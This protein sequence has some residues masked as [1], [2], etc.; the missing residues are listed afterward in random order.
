VRIFITYDRED[1]PTVTQ[2]GADLE[3]SEREVWIEQDLTGGQSWWEEILNH[4]R[5]CDLYIFAL[6]EFSLASRPCLRELEYA[7]A[8]G[9]PILPV[10]V[11]DVSIQQAPQVIVD[12]QVVNYIGRSA[13]GVLALRDALD[14]APPAPA[15]PDP[16]PSPPS[17]PISYFGTYREQ[18]DADSLCFADQQSLLAE[19]AGYIAND[20]DRDD[21]VD[22]LGALRGRPDVAY[23]VV[24]EIDAL[25]ES[26]PTPA[27]AT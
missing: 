15:L 12:S 1:A 13:D 14:A 9:R 25:L 21:A 4:I 22:L 5:T 2:L 17:V 8:L 18:V 3:G 26:I 10:M 16:L 11:S 6:S 20:D 19:L 23:S 27:P 24:V 7:L